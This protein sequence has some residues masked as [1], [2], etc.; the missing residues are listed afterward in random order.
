MGD[1]PDGYVCEVVA[2][3]NKPPNRTM[4]K[5]LARLEIDDDLGATADPD[6][7]RRV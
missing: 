3:S 7:G 6:D 1:A 5:R 4:E 2:E